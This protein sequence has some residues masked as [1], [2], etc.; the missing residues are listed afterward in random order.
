MKVASRDLQTLLSAGTLGG[1]SDGSLLERFAA[2]REQAAFETL[3]GRHG[4]MVWGVCRRLLRDHHD[5]EDAFQATFLVLARKG[6]SIV[7]RELLGNWLYGVAYQTARKARSTRSK[8]R[9]RESQV[10]EMPEPEAPPEDNHDDFTELLDG[11]LSRLPAKYRLPIVLCDLEGTSHKEAADQLGW[12]IG[13]VAGRLARAR[14]ILAQRLA[15]RGVSL[16]VAALAGFLA[17]RSASASMPRRLIDSTAGTASLIEA[18]KAA[19]AGMVS[20]EVA[21]LTGEVLKIMFLSKIKIISAMLLVASVVVAGGAG[22]TY[23]ARATEPTTQDAEKTNERSPADSNPPL[24]PL[25][26]LKPQDRN[27]SADPPRKPAQHPMLVRPSPKGQLQHV[28]DPL[29]DLIVGGTLRPEQLERAKNLIESM[30]AFE[31]EI[32]GMTAVELDK[33]IQETSAAL[34]EARWEVR[35]LDTQLRRLKKIRDAQQD[36]ARETAPKK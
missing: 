4:P 17:Q 34:E 35:L 26:E 28:D 33:M 9:L 23:R 12:P 16:S 15:R 22:L 7:H 5:A 21:A 14:A 29:A 24:S 13:T 32:E 19:T 25:E 27:A 1:L 18:G 20:A 8:K 10:S 6:H 3:V 36:A 30:L 31:K 11:E 2:Y